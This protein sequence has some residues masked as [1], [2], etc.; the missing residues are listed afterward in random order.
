MG[1]M[2]AHGL[3]PEDATTVSINWC[4][5]DLHQTRDLNDADYTL[6]GENHGTCGSKICKCLLICTHKL[7]SFGCVYI[8]VNKYDPINRLKYS[9]C[10][11]DTT[12]VD[13]LSAICYPSVEPKL[14]TL[15]IHRVGC[16]SSPIY[17]REIDLSCKTDMHAANVSP[18]HDDAPDDIMALIGARIP[19]IINYLWATEFDSSEYLG[20]RVLAKIALL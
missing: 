11:S 4:G 19:H 8:V 10:L 2:K 17:R 12:V 5:V 7:M 6:C 13:A 9:V 20:P 15:S 14:M 1:R 18:T 3:L 16:V